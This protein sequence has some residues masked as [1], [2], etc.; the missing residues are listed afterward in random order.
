M[1]RN[2]CS[3]T[4]L[5]NLL[6]ITFQ[7]FFCLNAF[8]QANV[9][10]NHNDLKRTGW[11]SNE[12]ILAV[13]NVS[14]GNFGEIFSRQVD[15]QIYAQPLVVSNVSVGGG[16]HN[17]VIVATV[18]NTLYAF[19]ADDPAASIPYWQDNLTYDSSNYRPIRNT[20]MI[21]ACSGQL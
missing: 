18:N 4:F 12:T 15:D 5:R 2:F 10:M 14:S 11:N 17:I 9:I 6:I 20:D 1:D 7:V 21:Y 19:D 16:M 8:S 13:G 3:S